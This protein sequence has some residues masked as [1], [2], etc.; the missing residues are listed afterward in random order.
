MTMQEMAK[1]LSIPY[2]KVKNKVASMGLKEKNLKICSVGNIRFK[3]H[4]TEEKKKKLDYII[5][6]KQLITRGR[7]GDVYR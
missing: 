2:S 6:F 3:Y 4:T 1:E 7:I 5:M